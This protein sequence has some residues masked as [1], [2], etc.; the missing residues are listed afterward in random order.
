MRAV[1][2]SLAVAV[3]LLGSGMR[4]QSL[5]QSGGMSMAD[6]QPIRASVAA[7][8][9]N[10]EGSIPPSLRAAG[11]ETIAWERFDAGA[12]VVIEAGA[13]QQPGIAGVDDNVNGTPDDRLELGATGSDD[14]CRVVPAGHS[15]GPADTSLPLQR[16]AF[17]PASPPTD[18]PARAIVSG[19]CRDDQGREDRWSFLIE[20]VPPE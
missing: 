18:P 16:G 7:Q 3:L 13:D 6:L 14:V 10:L 11:V 15:I 8:L 19:R 20:V 1:P 4:L 17:V 12:I 2:L 5:K 9:P